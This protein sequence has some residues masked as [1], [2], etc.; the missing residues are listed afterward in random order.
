MFL[1]DWGKNLKRNVTRDLVDG[2]IFQIPTFRMQTF[3][4]LF[5]VEIVFTEK[6]DRI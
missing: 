1:N 5:G 4:L 6:M 3:G 2:V